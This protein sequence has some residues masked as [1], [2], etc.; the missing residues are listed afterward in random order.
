MTL[1][2]EKRLYVESYHSYYISIYSSLD[3][4]NSSPLY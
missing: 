2:P 3:Y 4:F 1:Q